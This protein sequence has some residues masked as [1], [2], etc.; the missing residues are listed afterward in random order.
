MW[1]RWRR[2]RR[3]RRWRILEKDGEDVEEGV[4]KRKEEYEPVTGSASGC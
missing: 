3:L 2:W 4:C 1:R